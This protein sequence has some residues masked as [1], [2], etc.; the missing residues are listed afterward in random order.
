MTF[1]QRSLAN[2]R[3]L[4]FFTPDALWLVNDNWT[5]PSLY[6]VDVGTEHITSFITFVNQ[7][8]QTVDNLW[9]VRCIARDKM[10]NLW[11]GT[12]VGPLVLSPEE[13][14][15]ANPIFEQIKIPRNDGTT[16]ADYLLSGV[17]I[18]NIVI[19]NANRK[20]MATQSNGLYLVS[21]DNQRQLAHYTAENSPLLSNAIE[22]LAFDNTTGTLYIGTAAGLCSVQS[23]AF[24]S[25]DALQKDRV[26]AYPNPVEPG[27][28]GPIN[29][30]GLMDDSDVK[31]TT[32]DGRLVKQ[33][34]SNGAL[35]SWDG[36][37]QHGQRV[38][39][40]IYLVEV[41][42]PDGAKGVV[43]RVAIVN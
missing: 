7:D 10:R 27:Y 33:G 34:R 11:V 28:T 43:C 35:F 6:R 9:Y 3:Q 30:V 22:S 38:A 26:Y 18:T 42:T 2:G 12:N 25:A 1:G 14:Q 36:T 31:I 21:S 4:Q 41:A 29:I 24:L 17:D 23:E 37:N 19:D 8:G 13:A 40:G 39:S 15:K 32:V 20:W 16:L 5:R